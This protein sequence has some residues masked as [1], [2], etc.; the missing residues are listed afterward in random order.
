[1]IEISDI[2]IS[3]ENKDYFVLDEFVRQGEF[4]RTKSGQ[5]QRYVGGFT[6]VFPVVVKHE[7]WA[8]RCWHA[9]LGNVRRRFLTIA[10]AIKESK[11]RYLCDFAYVDEGIAINGK[12]YPTTR[13]R[14]V[15]GYTLKDYICE[16]VN[17]ATKLNALAK[18][19]LDLVRDMHSHGFAH[20]DLQHGNIIVDKY[21]E[22]YLVD[23]DSF[24]CQDLKGESDI[25]TGLDDYQ[26][27]SRKRNILVNE[28]LDYFSEL[29]IYLSILAIAEKPS[30]SAKYN[31]PDSERML[32]S[33]SDY[34]DI[35]QSAVYTDLQALSPTIRHLLDVLCIYLSKATLD[36]LEPFDV[37]MDRL[38][39]SPEIH[40]FSTTADSFLKGDALQ[41]SW[42]IENYTQVLLN[43]KDVTADTHIEE[44]ADSQ[45]TYTLEVFNY[46]K[47]ISKSLHI[48]ILLRPVISFSTDKKKLH[49]NKG[50]M[51]TLTWDVQNA[52]QCS[53]IAPDGTNENCEPQG[54]A[55]I[56]PT[57]T[58]TYTLRTLALDKR[59]TIDTPLTINVYPDA[60]VEFASDKGYTFPS[61]PFTLSWQ[62]RYAKRVTLNGKLVKATDT[63]TY[64][65]GIE[66]DTTYVLRVTDEFGEKD[67]PLTIKML[68]I[69]QIKTIL[70]PTP[71]VNENINI[72]T[73][74]PTPTL[75][76]RFPQP[77]LQNLELLDMNKYD[78]H[79]ET[80]IVPP[81]HLIVPRFEL[82]EQSLFERIYNKLNKIL[83]HN[84]NEIK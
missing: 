55:T 14:W 28:K 18:H 78:V 61:I 22:L 52:E 1:M 46:Q 62:V 81:I 84:G 24:Y 33:A 11:A 37:V 20:G 3:V 57:E 59:T 17:D 83:K 12:K 10:K 53:L 71:H 58:C 67:Y 27:P 38:T 51:V 16:N 4:L 26:H 47:H 50:E 2:I 63:I 39:Q 9:D 41:L 65:S 70:I 40:S 75:N 76:I 77:R 66:K 19:F 44:V 23:Y 21:G 7:K 35:T 30:L 49:K 31:V 43:G 5:L 48:S 54:A 29:I 64:D 69:S 45:T 74:V 60:Q 13:M 8:F 73:N 32:F 42:D 15:D 36:D 56:T 80:N 34:Q 6:A 68:P 82:E 25:I 72:T 79:V